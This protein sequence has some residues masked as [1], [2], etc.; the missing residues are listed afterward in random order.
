MIHVLLLGSGGRE[1]AIASALT[2]STNLEL[3]A[4]MSSSNPGIIRLAKDTKICS[5]NNPAQVSAYAK[6]RNVELAIIGPE[7]PLVSGVVDVLTEQG[8]ICVGPT[9]RLATLEGDKAFC[10]NLLS[11][12]KIPGNPKYR[13]FTAL[14]PALAFLRTTK[15]PVVLKPIGL[16]GGKGVKVS[17]ED[18]P[19]KESELAYAKEIIQNKIGGSPKLLIEER[20][21]GEEYSL[22]AF[23]DGHDVHVMPIVQD[24]KRA[25]ENDS[26]PNTGGMGSYSDNNHLLPFLTTRDLELSSQIM[27]MTINALSREIGEQYKG[28][29]Y[30]QFMLAK[31]SDDQFPT[32][33]LIEFNCRF[34]DPEAMNVLP[35]LTSDLLDICQRIGDG[36]LTQN[37]V[38]FRRE[39]SVCKYLVPEG[40]PETPAKDENIDVDEE[41]VKREGAQ[42]YFA[43]VNVR[44]GNIVTTSSR[45]LAVVGTSSTIEEAEKIS[46]SATRHIK[47]RLRHRTDI[48][49]AQSIRKRLS[50]T[51]SIRTLLP[52]AQT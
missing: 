40:Y 32:P 12:H 44:N 14:D 37:A 26:G 25:Y 18:L 46:E 49:S 28:I 17:V 42:L 48:G 51:E 9:Q 19:T 6:S 38:C 7:V 23:V 45:T 29:L 50:H 41:A 11:R 34:G 39:A 47:G 21:E 13:I 30:G 52:P 24:H 43:N 36:N 20:L 10:R 4:A 27:S 8:I 1:H 33:K 35:L 3:Y 5:I 31:S 15:E 22:Q 2:K 16:T